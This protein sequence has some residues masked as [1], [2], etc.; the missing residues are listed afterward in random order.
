MD[1]EQFK[2]YMKESVETVT[3]R[4]AIVYPLLRNNSLV[5]DSLFLETP[6]GAPVGPAPVLWDYYKQ[7]QEGASPGMLVN[8]MV[9]ICEDKVHRL[10]INV[11]ILK[12]FAK[13]RGKICARLISRERNE[14]L[15]DRVPHRAFLDLEIVYYV[16]FPE[17]STGVM[18]MRIEKEHLQMWGVTEE[19]IWQAA[20]ENMPGLLPPRVHKMQDL[21]EQMAGTELYF[22]LKEE[23]KKVVGM[24]KAQQRMPLFMMTN[25][26]GFHGASVLLYNGLLEQ[27]ARK[28]PGDVFVIPS[29]VHEVLLLPAEDTWSVQEMNEMIRCVNRTEVEPEEILSDHVYIYRKKLGKLMM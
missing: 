8:D 21:L 25:S 6:E 23:E 4:K 13:M 2:M 1:Y 11:Q 20:M 18:S 9:G 3:G 5:R 27:C 17:I 16:F 22:H 10:Q 12:E 24:V 28:F 14:Q 29:S 7:Y 19:E 26:R 15:L